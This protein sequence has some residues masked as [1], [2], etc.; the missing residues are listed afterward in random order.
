MPNFLILIF[1]S[2]SL[3]ASDPTQELMNT[4]SAKAIRVGTGPDIVYAFI[5]PLCSKSK[6]FITRINE[7]KELKK[8]RSY[9]IFLNRLQKFKSDKLIQYIY[10]AKHPKTALDEIM[11]YDDIPDLENFKVQ[12]NTLT[13]INKVAKIAKKMKIKRRPYLLIYE[14][15]SPYCIVSE[16]SAPCLEDEDF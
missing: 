15:G 12:K 2:F 5:D 16:G 13:L 1:L 9:Y 10:Q 14:K 11:I 7:S 6:I 3:M 8:R 4:I